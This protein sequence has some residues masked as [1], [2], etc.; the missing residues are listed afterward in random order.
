[1]G[2]G[3]EGE[4]K[5]TAKIQLKVPAFS[6]VVDLEV[7]GEA[8]AVHFNGVEAKGALPQLRFLCEQVGLSE[9]DFLAVKQALRSAGLRVPEPP[10]P[11]ELGKLLPSLSPLEALAFIE[12][13]PHGDLGVNA[14][15]NLAL[16]EGRVSEEDLKNPWKALSKVPSHVR[17]RLAAQLLEE[18][19]LLR[20]VA[21]N[22]ARGGE[23]RATGEAYEGRCAPVGDRIL[24]P[25]EK[26]GSVASRFFQSALSRETLNYVKGN[27]NVLH[28]VEV[29]LERVNPWHQLRLKGWILDLRDLKLVPPSLSDY[30]FTYQVDLRVGEA[31]LR[32]LVESVRKGEYSIEGNSVFR[33]WKPHFD[34]AGKREWEGFIDAVGT[35]LAP[36]RF[37]SL[38]LLV[39]PKDAGKSTLLYVLTQPIDPLV[40]RVPLSTLASKEG[41]P[42]QPLI[43][44]WIN[45]YSEQLSPSIKNLQAINNLVGESDWIYVNRKHLPAI[46]IRSLKSMLFASNA[47]PIV[48]SWDPSTMDAFIGRLSIVF[49]GKPKGYKPVLDIAESVPSVDRFAFNLWCR[50]QLEERGWKLRRRSEGRLLELLLEAQNPVTRFIA[51]RCVTDPQARVERKKLYEAFVE[52]LKEKGVTAVPTRDQFYLQVRSMHYVDRPWKGKYYFFGLRLAEPTEQ[53]ESSERKEKQALGELDRFTEE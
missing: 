8:V 53:G 17:A 3:E 14:L 38:T 16:Q 10:V 49:I 45:V 9:K 32:E 47:V 23:E 24:L 51:E 46:H 2:S 20:V 6:G 29:P 48:T 22:L 34:A 11:V 26:W 43:G 21:L 33:L 44:K 52:W 25:L 19:G 28:S 15:L 39:G 30:W 1:V 7:Y 40:G 31:E 35:W 41:F 50:K 18:W 37:K 36:F 13:L 4:Y 42:Y 27:F 12:K 5:G